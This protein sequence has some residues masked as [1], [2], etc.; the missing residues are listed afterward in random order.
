MLL[1]YLSNLHIVCLTIV[2]WTEVGMM[3]VRPKC[4]QA[5][6]NCSENFLFCI[7]VAW[8]FSQGN[9]LVRDVRV[10]FYPGCDSDLGRNCVQGICV[11]GLPCSSDV[12]WFF[13]CA[14]VAMRGVNLLL[15]VGTQRI[16]ALLGHFEA[17][18]AMTAPRNKEALRCYC[19]LFIS[20]GMIPD[21]A[22]KRS[23]YYNI[24]RY[25]CE[26]R[27]K[28]YNDIPVVIVAKSPF[29]TV[30]AASRGHDHLLP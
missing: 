29:C 16:D 14:E 26:T 25:T 5:M 2:E 4:W 27:I 24:K 30:V 11:K 28:Q 13:Q 15:W 10:S 17:C 7:E 9:Y 20:Y 23:S 12:A 6:D 21:V 3:L 19:S 18:I 1:W 8:P 22:A